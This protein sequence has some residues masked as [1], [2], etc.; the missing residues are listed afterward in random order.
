MTE[1][2]IGR[3]HGTDL[4]T[5]LQDF[6]RFWGDRER[7]RP[8]HHPMF[9][10]EFGDTALAARR[11]DGQLLGYLLGFVTPTRDAYV[12]L[13]AVRDDARG[14]GLARRLY[15]AF[16][17]AALT[18]GAVAL[19]AI[20]SPENK[21]SQEFHRALGFTLSRADD[22]G[23]TGQAR[24]VMRKDLDTATRTGGK[25]I[26]LRGMAVTDG[27]SSDTERLANRQVSP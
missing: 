3:A 20:T 4:A 24:V 6:P 13:V 15:G 12:H 7:L 18:R 17:D 2:P 25:T 8:L 22:Y 19:K 16:T 21:G 9:V 23:G 27:G 11:A 10:L 26:A 5:I 1:V 14:L